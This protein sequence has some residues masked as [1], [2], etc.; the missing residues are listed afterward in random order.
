MQNLYRTNRKNFLSRRARKK[1][2][3]LQIFYNYIISCESSILGDSLSEFNDSQW[4]QDAE[5]YIEAKKIL[6]RKHLAS[7]IKYMDKITKK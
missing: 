3:K 1:F 6:F 2:L 4:I 5:K 7:Y